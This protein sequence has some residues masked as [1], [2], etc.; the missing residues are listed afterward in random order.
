MMFGIK[1]S[2]YCKFSDPGPFIGVLRF[3][4]WKKQKLPESISLHDLFH[5]TCSFIKLLWPGDSKG[6]FSI[7]ESSLSP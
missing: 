1:G 4:Q 2:Y 5:G 7:F 3:I 6:T